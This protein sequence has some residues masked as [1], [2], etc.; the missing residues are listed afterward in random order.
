MRVIGEDKVGTGNESPEKSFL[1]GP[2]FV[3]LLSTVPVSQ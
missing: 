1:F 3:F 2:Q